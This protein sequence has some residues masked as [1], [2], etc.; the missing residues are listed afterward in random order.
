MIEWT[1]P[2]WGWMVFGFVLLLLEMSAAGGFYF[3]FF[4]VGAIVVGILA[5]LDVISQAWV[6]LAFFSIVSVVASLLF[7]KPLMAK[8]GPKEGDGHVDSFVGEAAVVLDE[9]PVNGIGK[10]EL[11]GST[12]NARSSAARALAKGERCMVERVEGLS[13]WVKAEGS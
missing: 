13:V 12:W 6:Q 7:R 10:V 2:W 3:L 11:R 4:G 9:I 1:I 8:F 5:W